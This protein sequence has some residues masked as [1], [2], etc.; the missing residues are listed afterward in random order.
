MYDKLSK[1]DEFE[2]EYTKASPERFNTKWENHLDGNS[3]LLWFN[4]YMNKL[5][6]FFC[7]EFES[8]KK[9]F[10]DARAPF[11]LCSIIKHTMDPTRELLAVN[12]KL[13][14][15]SSIA[16]E[17]FLLA[18][19]CA[20]KFL[21]HLESVEVNK[22]FESFEA[23]FGPFIDFMDSY[24]DLEASSIKSSLESIV[25]D[26]IFKGIESE[27][28][29]FSDPDRDTIQVFEAYAERFLRVVNDSYDPIYS[30]IKRSSSYLNGI[31]VKPIFRSLS[32]TIINFIRLLL[33]KISE[34]R[35]A[36]GIEADPSADQNKN[37]KSNFNESNQQEDKNTSSPI[38][39][40]W[41]QKLKSQGIDFV[42]VG[43]GR[44]MIPCVLR[45]LQSSGR[46][47]QR[48]IELEEESSAALFYTFNSLFR[49]NFPDKSFSHSIE[50]NAIS[51]GLTFVNLYLQQEI[52]TSAELKS[53]LASL[54]KNPGQTNVQ[55][56]SSPSV[57]SSVVPS[58]SKLKLAS[59]GLLFDICTALPRKLCKDI[60]SDD[61]WG[62]GKLTSS[63]LISTL[64][65]D[66]ENMLP[67]QIFTQV[68]NKNYILILNICYT[69]F[70][71]L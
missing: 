20:G 31:R 68:K 54:A 15:L 39:L 5:A 25:G 1:G 41:L 66:D 8:A 62:V 12:L 40:M 34:L 22:R 4:G 33:G 59:G 42:S 26:I 37:S 17:S 10:G 47:V 57:F 55:I 63:D 50:S 16:S 61:I 67:Q 35:D 19:K 70:S 69:L 46:L 13:L 53:Y 65:Q 9:I 11:L 3:F 24:V 56:S 29:E 60:Y 38:S 52:K 7:D 14:G 44:Q 6:S 36:L 58:I 43:A 27:L 49:D 71:K 30:S 28:D 2:E 51:P 23:Y 48:I 18:D 32:V 21:S 64:E 45:I